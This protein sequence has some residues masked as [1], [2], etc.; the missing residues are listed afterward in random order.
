MGNHAARTLAGVADFGDKS[1]MVTDGGAPA[2]AHILWDYENVVIPPGVRAAA[3]ALAVVGVAS[4]FGTVERQ[5]VF[6]KDNNISV[7]TSDQLQLCGFTVEMQR[8]GKPEQV[9]RHCLARASPPRPTR[10]FPRV[11]LTRG[12][13]LAAPARTS[14]EGVV[15]TRATRGHHTSSHVWV[16]SVLAAGGQGH[17]DRGV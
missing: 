16:A 3:V 1:D 7:E 10:T 14:P 15:D 9:R 5:R 11:L 17:P 13:P 6:T 4:A 2:N 8:L 12:G